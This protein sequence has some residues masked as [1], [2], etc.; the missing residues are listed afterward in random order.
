VKGRKI[1]L[2]ATW[3]TLAVAFA[4]L[5]A[6]TVQARAATNGP[7]TAMTVL[8]PNGA[9]G[10]QASPDQLARKQ[11]LP[12]QGS[13][14]YFWAEAGVAAAVLAGLLML[15]LWGDL[16]IGGLIVGVGLLAS[17]A[18]LIARKASL[19]ARDEARAAGRAA[20]VL[21]DDELAE[22]Y[23][24]AAAFIRERR[25]EPLAADAGTARL[26]LGRLDEGR[27]FWQWRRREVSPSR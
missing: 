25:S 1:S 20:A 9:A 14:S 5:A 16:A 4:V 13:A 6:P 15:G 8:R 23:R 3:L 18:A 11:L 27:F 19:R 24:F 21:T 7:G 17:G 12:K 10:G 22:A 26:R 2:N